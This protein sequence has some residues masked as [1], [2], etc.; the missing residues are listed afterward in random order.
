MMIH[1]NFTPPPRCTLALAAE[2]ALEVGSA[3]P[4]RLLYECPWVVYRDVQRRSERLD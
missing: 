2:E 3:E 4:E 1:I